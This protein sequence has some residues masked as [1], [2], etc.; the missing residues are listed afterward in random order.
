MQRNSSPIISKPLQNKDI[1]DKFLTF[2]RNAEK[3]TW[4]NQPWYQGT[5]LHYSDLC[6]IQ[7]K[8]SQVCGGGY[9]NPWYQDTLRFDTPLYSDLLNPLEFFPLVRC[10]ITEIDGHVAGGNANENFLWHRDE[11]PHEVLRVI[12]PLQTSTEYQFQLDNYKPINLAVGQVYAFDQ[13]ILHRIYKIGLPTV[14]RI[15][16]VLS[17]VTWFSKSNDSWVPNSHANKIHP[18]DLFDKI[19]L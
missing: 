6:D 10:K 19:L 2:Y 7:P 14:S 13:S 1:I 8:S 4:H 16:L 5:G 12:V 11:R 9:K 15:H 3:H 17:Y 18:M